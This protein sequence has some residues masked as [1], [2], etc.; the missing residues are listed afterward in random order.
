MKLAASTQ[1][2]ILGNA[3]SGAPQAAGATAGNAL[4][5]AGL[6]QLKAA[7]NAQDPQSILATA[8]QFEAV[9]LQQMLSA[10]DATSFGSDLT[11]KN[12]GPMFQ[13]LF[14]QQ[15]AGNV[16]QGK[17]IGLAQVLAKEMASRYHLQW[18]KGADGKAPPATAF[19]APMRNGGLAPPLS[20]DA[21]QGQ[22]A[23][24]L[25]Q[26]ARNFV[27][28]ILPAVQTAAQRLG[29]SP[30]AI[31]AQ[32]ALE[33]GWGTHVAGNNL[34]GIKGGG[35]WQGSSLAELTHEVRNGLSQTETA[36]FRTYDNMAASVHNY[37]SLLLHNARYQG[38]LGQGDN[39][40]AFATALQ[41]AGYA[42]D[43]QYASKVVAVAQSPLMQAATAGLP[44]GGG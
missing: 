18:G 17:G 26:Q 8:K 4:D 29:V 36:A 13:S 39:V 7:A 43:P 20:A 1:A 19:A 14:N 3:R 10:M 9:L 28:S 40:G 38:A 12:A 5:F 33:T 37:A 25:V 16:A 21:T 32:A 35:S 44:L 22:P 34:F 23:P 6:A 41:S 11:G 31:I 15:I 27:E 24:E 2:L 42:T 30:K